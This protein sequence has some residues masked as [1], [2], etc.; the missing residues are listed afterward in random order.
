MPGWI[1]E[2]PLARSLFLSPPSLR[3]LPSLSLSL[4]PLS[5]FSFLS[6]FSLFL[7][8]SILFAL[9]LSTSLFL[10][11]S[12]PPWASLAQ[13]IPKHQDFWGAPVLSMGRACIVGYWRNP[14]W[15]PQVS[16]TGGGWG[17]TLGGKE[18]G[19]G[20]LQKELQKVQKGQLDSGTLGNNGER[21]QVFNPSQCAM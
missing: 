11:Y 13:G 12:L 2:C 6:S 18:K 17:E 7:S 10:S 9:A 3:S 15:I 19:E 16:P 1:T 4:S 5:S 20:E 14:T 21:A 8:S